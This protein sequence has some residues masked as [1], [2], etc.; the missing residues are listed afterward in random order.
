MKKSKYRLN[1]RAVF[2]M[3]YILCYHVT[4]N[5]MNC[6][7]M[8][9]KK[10]LLPAVIKRINRKKLIMPIMF[11]CFIIA[12]FC[13]T[14][15]HHM[16]SMPS[17]SSPNDA[18][19]AYRN[20]SIFVN[21]KLSN[22]YYSGVNRM[23]GREIKGCYYYC[24]YENNCYYILI[25]AKTLGL[26]EANTTPPQ[27]IESI[28]CKARL[29]QNPSEISTLTDMVSKNLGWTSSAL[30]LM[31]SKVLLDQYSFSKGREYILLA[32][33]SCAVF[34]TLIH[35]IIVIISLINPLQ[36]RAVRRLSRY[37]NANEL[38]LSACEEYEDSHPYAPGITLTDH[39]FI[40]YDMH[41]I[42]IVPLDVIVWA[43][44]FGTLHNR[45]LHSNISYSLSV[46]AND[47]KHYIV[48]R[49]TKDAVEL[50][51]N[52]LQTRFPEI[53]IGYS[54]GRRERQK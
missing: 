45:L 8:Y 54:E 31:S 3:T 34:I 40:G 21:A 41:N 9:M 33:I 44:K 50:V 25:S 23:K 19:A 12:V 22:L 15:L 17:V 2:D 7:T 1:L 5:F 43:Y 48:H 51:L 27:Y 24:L 53:L 13:I 37:G 4:R 46:V 16:F 49:K 10:Y 6:E 18:A 29:E 47:K 30:N 14:P 26:N 36:S 38:F 35:L 39:F 42:H 20:G 11:L 32:V 28:V 52:A